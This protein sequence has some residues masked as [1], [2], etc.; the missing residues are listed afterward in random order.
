MQVFD[1]S[2]VKYQLIETKDKRGTFLKEM[3]KQKVVCF[4]TETT[5][6]DANAAELVGMSFSWK[7]GEAYYIPLPENE[8]GAKFI[9]KDFEP[10]FTAIKSRKLATT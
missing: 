2:R 4:D 7:K 6:V 10:F 3:M 5:S 9:L 8:N 1:E